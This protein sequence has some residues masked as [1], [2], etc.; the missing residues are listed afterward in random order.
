VEDPPD[1]QRSGRDRPPSGRALPAPGTVRLDEPAGRWVLL[2]TVLGSGVAFLD[3][4][5]VNI[6]LPRLGEDLGATMAGLQWTINAYTL[7][8]AAL[9]LL[10]GAL[11]D[12]LGRRRIFVVGVLWFAAAS[13]LC[14]LAPTVGVLVGARA[15]QG[16][17]GALLTPGALALIQATFHPDDRARAIGAWS[18]LGGIAGALGPFLGGW[19]VAAASW[20]W[21]FL[22][23]VPLAVAVALVSVRRVPESVDPDVGGRFD[24]GG[25]ALG[26]LAL[27][28][29]TY[30]LIEAPEKGLSSA[31]VLISAV[32]GLA[33]G[34]VFLVRERRTA[35]PMLPLH[36]FASH[37]FTAANV[38]TLCVYAAL[39]GVFLF[40]VMQLQVVAGFSPVAAGTALLPVTLLL[41]VLSSRAG[42]LANRIGPRLPMTAGPA[43]AGAGLLLLAGIG[44]GASYAA[45]VL[46]GAVLLGLGL[47][48]TVAPLTTTVLAAVDVRQAGIAS[49]VNNAV[50]RAAGLLAVAVLPLLVGLSGTAYQDPGVFDGAYRRVMWI[51]AGL[52]FAGAALA[53]STVRNDVLRTDEAGVAEGHGVPTRRPQCAASCAVAAPPLE[54]DRR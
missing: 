49:G 34:V 10:G 20:R 14:G 3:A 27:A 18:G 17:G 12:R 48:L 4:T 26:A 16:V 36:I 9:I 43:L 19:L 37:Q 1:R 41:L 33:A 2:A 50:A 45:S 47:A 42:A 25:A 15:L 24:V 54:P 53:W 46:P 44:P 52:L 5:V 38:V 29:V 35:H 28:G 13:V 40:L 21:I 11:G 31:A 30:A 6:A 7:T 23:N 51:C 8:L 22:L 32:A 39:G